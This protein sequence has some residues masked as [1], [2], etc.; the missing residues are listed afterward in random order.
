MKILQDE[1][2]QKLGV[3]WVVVN[4]NGFKV[5]ANRF[6]LAV[7]VL[8]KMPL[9]VSAA[10]FCYKDSTLRPYA[11]GFQL[12]CGENERNRMR[13][14]HGTPE[15]IEFELQTFG[16]PT[17][18]LSL[19]SDGGCSRT[20]HCIWLRIL[21]IHEEAVAMCSSKIQDEYVIVPRRFDVLFG[22]SRLA[23][24]HTGTRRARHIVE[25]HFEAYEVLRKYRKTD[26]AEKILAII[27]ESG[28]RFL[29][30]DSQGAWVLA[31]DIE[32]RKKIAHWFRYLREQKALS[33][34][35]TGIATPEQTSNAVGN[36]G[37]AK[38]KRAISY[39]EQ[40]GRSGT[41]EKSSP[42]PPKEATNEDPS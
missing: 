17:E 1:E 41:S 40:G 39:H 4:F 38:T 10:H 22:K 30:Q 18:D 33:V 23:R 36:P 24:N 16:I 21:K 27:H 2:T 20:Q 15:E 29:R 31:D 37:E 7:D 28:G 35:L 34:Q 9:R 25:M 6:Q 3:V 32:A 12:F 42:S 13:M 19:T 26:V 8:S 5:S 11:T 14:H